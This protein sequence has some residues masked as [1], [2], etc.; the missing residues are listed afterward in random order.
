MVRIQARVIVTVAVA[1]FVHGLGCP[2]AR[3]EAPTAAQ[4]LILTPIQPNASYD[5]PGEPEI[6]KC[7]IRAER[8]AGITSWIVRSGRGETLRRF[9]DTNAD[10]IVDQWC[11]FTGGLETYRDIDADFNGKADNYRWYHTSGTRWG[12][13]KN[14]DGRI[15][16]WKIISAPEVA[17]ELVWAIKMRDRARFELL[18]MKPSELA[19]IGFGK[20]RIETLS[21]TLM[22]APARFSKLAADQTV[23]TRASE[24]VDFYRSRPATIPVGTEGS[25]KDI[26]V[27]DNASALVET[28][29]K[30]DQL[31]LGTL[32][33]VGDTWRLL[34]VPTIGSTGQ[35]QNGLIM[36]ANSDGDA[37]VNPGGPS[38]EMQKLM[39]Q[40]ETLD[41]QA[42]QLQPSD[43]AANTDQRADVLAQ[44]AKAADDDEMRG[45]WIRQLADMLVSAIQEGNY[46]QGMDRLSQLIE[47]LT[48]ED[49][50]DPLIGY[51]KF[52]KMWAEYGL[53]QQAPDAD[54]A[55][56]QQKWQVDLEEFA[57]QNANSPE[58]AE[59]MLQLGM[60]HE[61]AGRLD[62]AKQWYQKL[63]DDFPKKSQANKARGALRRLNS[64]GKPFRFREKDRRG[65]LVDLAA[66]PYRGKVV[67]IQYWATWDERCKDD[68]DKLKELY[69]KYGGRNGYFEIIGVCLDVSPEAMQAFLTENRYPWQ[70]LHEPGGIDG[71]LA[72]ELG[73]MTLPLM[74]LVDQK[75]SV[76]DDSIFVA[77]LEAELKRLLG[78][79]T[80]Q[81]VG[82]LPNR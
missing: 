81:G 71:R 74:I 76:V 20:R 28:G 69:A 5:R 41:R 52:R 66:P 80:A 40:L 53:S 58:A 54:I 35:P 45:E 11:Y 65:N 46:P 37:A 26:V 57:N 1:C 2:W 7:T 43:R 32:I 55:E 75:G 49:Q 16:S 10:N 50:D 9:S 3:G 13:D 47:Q 61:F 17:E 79:A 33:A 21:A 15:D 27:H 68:M 38:D 30:H 59:A 36:A 64:V 72:N 12:I 44:L 39:A 73:V 56:I 18:L 24:F 51:A 29:D 82:A 34:D 23:V 4:A 22:S 19:D 77:E 60:S 8:Q 63:A 42:E 48:S 70:Q 25:T 31:F 78:T 14:E 62:P 67:L 6:A